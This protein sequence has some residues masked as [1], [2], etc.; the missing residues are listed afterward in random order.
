MIIATLQIWGKSHQTIVLEAVRY[1]LTAAN[2]G[3]HNF[4]TKFYSDAY[5]LMWTEERTGAV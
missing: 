4:R 3:R 5:P 1:V 2:Q